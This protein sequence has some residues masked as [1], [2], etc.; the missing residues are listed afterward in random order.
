MV[1]A[2]NEL[3]VLN[4]L[5]AFR[6]RSGRFLNYHRRSLP[7]YRGSESVVR[8]RPLKTG[9]SRVFAFPSPQPSATNNKFGCSNNTGQITLNLLTLVERAYI[10]RYY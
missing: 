3:L 6:C 1:F 9:C 8:S 4:G 10:E 7:Q 5:R 2:C